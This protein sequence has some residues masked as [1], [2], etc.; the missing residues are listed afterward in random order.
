MPTY[1]YRCNDCQRQIERI[2]KFSDDP[3]TTC[4]ACGGSL[5]RLL[6]PPAIIFK[7]SGWYSTDYGKSS[8]GNGSSRREDKTPETTSAET[9]KDKGAPEPANS[10]TNDD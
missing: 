1:V 5:K 8:S 10:S 2:Q 4:P 3:L 9:S 7:G 6:F